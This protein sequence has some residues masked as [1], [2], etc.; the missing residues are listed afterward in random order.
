MSSKHPSPGD[1]EKSPTPAEG[2]GPG[3]VEDVLSGQNRGS[4]VGIT[5][6]AE[7]R[8]NRKNDDQD[9]AK[10]IG[11]IDATINYIDWADVC[12]PK[13]ADKPEEPN[14][15]RKASDELAR[16]NSDRKRGIPPPVETPKDSTCPVPTCQIRTKKMKHHAW[17]FHL[18]F[19]FRDKINDALENEMSFQQ[20]RG[21]AILHL[22]KVIIGKDATIRD[23]VRFVNDTKT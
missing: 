12:V 3:S 16:E 8:E 13:E 10:V 6:G 15:K 7:P 21:E 9:I 20:L 4:H 5:S 14:R 1:G 23:L 22:A 18:P 19:M 17:Y 11:V 2:Y